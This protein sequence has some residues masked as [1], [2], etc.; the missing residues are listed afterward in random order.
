[1]INF[2][3][4]YNLASIFEH[5]YFLIQQPTNMKKFLAVLTI[6]ATVAA[7]NDSSNG[8]TTSDTTSTTTTVTTDSNTTNNMT[9]GTD[10]AAAMRMDTS[11]SRM[12]ATTDT[13]HK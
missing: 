6:A 3:V 11:A 7:C 10:T 5:T 12:N 4:G 2:L 9:T 1:L 13:T 8:T